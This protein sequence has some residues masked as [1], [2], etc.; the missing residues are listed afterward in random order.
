M[1]LSGRTSWLNPHGYLPAEL[2][3]FLPF[4]KGMTLAYAALGLVWAALCFHYR[5]VLLPLQTYIGGVILLGVVEAVS[6][7]LA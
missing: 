4:F 7:R 1:L 6:T 2:Y 5:A 3:S